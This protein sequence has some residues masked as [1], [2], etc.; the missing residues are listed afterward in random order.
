[1]K[2]P[3]YTKSIKWVELREL[4]GVKTIKSYN[5]KFKKK[6]YT[7]P[8]LKK[9][10]VDLNTEK[11]FKEI[12]NVVDGTFEDKETGRKLAVYIKE[13]RGSYNGQPKDLP[14]FHLTNCSTLKQMRAAKRFHLRYVKTDRVDG[15]FSVIDTT[16]SI[17]GEKDRKL[18]L[19]VFCLRNLPKKYKVVRNDIESA[20]RFDITDYFKENNKIESTLMN[21]LPSTY[22]KDYIPKPRPK[23]ISRISSS[24]REKKNWT[25]EMCNARYFTNKRGLH[26]HHK[27]GDPSNNKESN[28]M[29]LCKSCH[30]QQPGHT[31]WSMSNVDYSPKKIK[32]VKS[33][34]INVQ[35]LKNKL[36]RKSIST[37]DAIGRGEGQQVEFKQSLLGGN[38]TKTIFAKSMVFNI[39]KSIVAF[40]NSDGGKLIIGVNDNGKIEGIPEIGKQ[41]K[42]Y[43]DLDLYFGNIFNKYLT[44]D[45]RESC[46]WRKETIQ[47]KDLFV[48]D[49]EKYTH[50]PVA[51]VLTK[52]ETHTL[53][54]RKIKLTLPEEGADTEVLIRSGAQK[55][56]LRSATAELNFIRKRF[57]KY[58]KFMMS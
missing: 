28:L 55:T 40:L 27:D 4:M 6:D 44:A 11:D 34:R 12:T 30:D 9:E 57:P 29:A 22:S 26:T 39:F 42:N 5:T 20:R 41:F 21:R 33:K 15:M 19:C 38:K 7:K 31:K 32:K 54:G 13:W 18:R 24:Y 10:G 1:M 14:R 48:I 58:Y 35:L 17:K 52:H 16:S 8:V 36:E 23:N 49:V 53:N 37:F 43:D 50:K 3:D 47:G 2:L 46:K 56:P 45:L 25:C 51:I